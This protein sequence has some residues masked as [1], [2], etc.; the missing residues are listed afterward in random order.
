ML[1]HFAPT[2]VDHEACRLTLCF[3]CNRLVANSSA[4]FNIVHSNAAFARLTGL[5]SD[6]ISGSPFSTLV[7]EDEEGSRQASLAECIVSSSQGKNKI[8]H[9]R[10]GASDKNK[11][12]LECQIKASPIV[13]RKTFTREVSDVSHFAI[14]ILAVGSQCS[15]NEESANP[16]EALV[17]HNAIGVM[18]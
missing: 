8:L 3:A 18:G 9:L 14:E 17:K 12:S 15:F 10:L 1:S 7:F 2:S 4:P 16:G 5:P 6:Q 11:K 13:D